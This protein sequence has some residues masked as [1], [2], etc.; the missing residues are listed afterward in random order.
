MSINENRWVSREQLIRLLGEAGA[1]RIIEI[2][3]GARI[4]VP[5]PDCS[6][7]SSRAFEQ[8]EV[9]L[10]AEIARK[11]SA[12]FGDVQ[13]TIPRVLSAARIR[14]LKLQAAGM[15]PR[16]IAEQARCSERYVYTVLARGR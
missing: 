5:S 4:W 2:F 12:A 14:I 15:S 13:V 10:G 8:L 16:E 3:G 7:K 9:K 1:A 6:K 11:F